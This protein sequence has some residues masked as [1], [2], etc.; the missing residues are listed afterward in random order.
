MLF[1]TGNKI[2]HCRKIILLTLA[3]EKKALYL[4]EEKL[5]TTLPV[6]FSY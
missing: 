2:N 6:R 5:T 1:F 4:F 3:E